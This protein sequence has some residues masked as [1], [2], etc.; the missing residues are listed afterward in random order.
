[1]ALQ[2]HAAPERVVT[3]CYRRVDSDAHSG[4]RVGVFYDD[5]CASF[6]ESAPW[7]PAAAFVMFE[8][9]PASAPD[10]PDTLFRDGE[11]SSR[12]VGP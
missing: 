1:M 5:G 9:S 2:W 10:T 12:A 8:V 4:F 11:K 3:S 7:R 6:F